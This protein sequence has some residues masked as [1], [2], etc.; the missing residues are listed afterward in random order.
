MIFRPV[1]RYALIAIAFLTPGAWLALALGCLKY[2]DAWPQTC[3]PVNYAAAPLA[4]GAV[5]GL[6]FGLVYLRRAHRRAT[7][8]QWRRAFIPGLR[9]LESA[10][11][12][13][14][15]TGKKVLA[16][17]D[18]PG[19]LITGEMRFERRRWLIHCPNGQR[20]HVDRAEFWRW[21]QA[22]EKIAAG[23]PPG[24]SAV[25]MRRWRGQVFE[26]RILSE[27]DVLAF[28]E[29]LRAVGA[30][31]W[32]TGDYRSMR[33]VACAGAVWG[34]VEAMEQVQESEGY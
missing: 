32:R 34:R 7:H 11:E 27:G 29:I 18:E 25:S 15:M 3:Q 33:Y 20:V 24:Q 31:E 21:L 10:T 1:T 16:W 26:G 17:S 30:L 22:V 23:L 13:V 2:G 28:R 12:A 4:I 8:G 19:D 5:V 9:T 14:W 6:W